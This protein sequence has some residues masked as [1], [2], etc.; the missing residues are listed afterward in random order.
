VAI[1]FDPY[2]AAA[3]GEHWR[4]SHPSHAQE[5]HNHRLLSG[6]KY[7]NKWISNRQ[8]GDY[9]GRPTGVEGNL[10][11][12]GEYKEYVKQIPDADDARALDTVFK[13]NNWMVAGDA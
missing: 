12:A 11:V 9:P 1:C 2:F 10:L 4:S 8:I 6:R 3:T 7:L 5:V 13:D